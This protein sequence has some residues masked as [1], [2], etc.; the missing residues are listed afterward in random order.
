MRQSDIILDLFQPDRSQG[1]WLEDVMTT[2]CP[3]PH[4]LDVISVRRGWL[5]VVNTSKGGEPFWLNPAHIVS[6]RIMEG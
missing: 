3:I 4:S 1:F 5:E 2:N 6:M